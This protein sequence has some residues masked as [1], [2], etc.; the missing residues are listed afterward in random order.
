MDQPRKCLDT[1]IDQLN[2]SL[3][4]LGI[5]DQLSHFKKSPRKPYGQPLS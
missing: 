4:E 5:G 2:Q 3:W 1:N